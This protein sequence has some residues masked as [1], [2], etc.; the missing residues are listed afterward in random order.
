[1]L[2]TAWAA[3][4]FEGEGCISIRPDVKSVILK[5]SSTD[6]DILDRF[7]KIVGGGAIYESKVKPGRK[8]CW[9]WNMGLKKDVVKTLERFL[10]YFGERRAYTALNAFDHYDGC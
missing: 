3:G 10:P 6:K 4:L 1:M 5:L 2:Q 9:E 8:P 7:H